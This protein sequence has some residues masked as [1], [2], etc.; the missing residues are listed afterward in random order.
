MKEFFSSVS[1]E[2]FSYCMHLAKKLIFLV[3]LKV[4]KVKR[5]SMCFN[6]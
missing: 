5:S 6:E 1:L 2:V 3:D 4:D